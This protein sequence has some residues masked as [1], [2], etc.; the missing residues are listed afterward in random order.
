[1]SSQTLQENLNS[2]WESILTAVL[3]SSMLKTFL[4]IILL[5]VDILPGRF[6]PPGYVLIVIPDFSYSYSG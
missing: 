3:A 5:L 2:I 4:K 1:M 6:V